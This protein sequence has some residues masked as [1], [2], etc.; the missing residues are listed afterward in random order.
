MSEG[1]GLVSEYESP[2]HENRAW[3]YDYMSTS[4]IGAFFFFFFFLCQ[5]SEISTQHVTT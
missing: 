3:E 5:I 1:N 2:K 4:F